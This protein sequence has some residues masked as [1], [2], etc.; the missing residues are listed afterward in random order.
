MTFSAICGSGEWTIKWKYEEGK[1]N[2]GK[3]KKERLLKCG[4]GEGKGRDNGGRGYAGGGGKRER[5][6]SVKRF[7]GCAG[8]GFSGFV[9]SL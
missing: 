4:K 2:G 9:L 8:K 3:R 7:T 6:D 5:C 1:K